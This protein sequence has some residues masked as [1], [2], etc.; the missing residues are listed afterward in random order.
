MIPTAE[1]SVKGF[2]DLGTDAQDYGN[3]IVRLH[4]A[5]P[6]T[7][8]PARDIRRNV[9]VRIETG[10]HD[11]IYAICRFVNHSDRHV[12][13][14]EYDARARLGVKKGQSVALIVRKARAIEYVGYLW[15]HPNIVVRIEFR[16]AIA[17]T[18][19]AFLLG[20]AASGLG[21]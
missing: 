3:G 5:L 20:L 21:L 17:L 11:R 4:H 9:L 6:D 19:A 8:A 16:L 7:Y 1:F 18:V 14:L 15:S 12:I 13:G 2:G 10:R